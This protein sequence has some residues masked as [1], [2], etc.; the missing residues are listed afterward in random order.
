MY[1]WPI[2]L[3][4]ATVGSEEDRERRERERERTSCEFLVSC[5]QEIGYSESMKATA[6]FTVL[7][8]LTLPRYYMS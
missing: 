6:V 5:V 4:I 2:G 1:D 8:Q 7:L 3:G